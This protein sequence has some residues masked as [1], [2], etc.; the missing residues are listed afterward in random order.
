[1]SVLFVPAG[2]LLASAPVSAAAMPACSAERVQQLLSDPAT[3]GA[4][5][6]ALLAD[7]AQADDLDR[8]TAMLLGAAARDLGD[9]DR[10]SGFFEKAHRAAP[11]DTA[12]TLEWAV[13]RERARD[14]QTAGTLYQQVLAS[15]PASRPA[16]LGLAR[17][18]RAQYR[19]AQA[20]GIYRE[21]LRA[22]AHDIDA[23][24]GLA[25]VDLAEQRTG[26]ARHG[27]EA[28]LASDPDNA[29]AHEGLRNVATTLPY[30]LDV[31]A[32][33][34][35]TRE[36]NAGSAAIL[37]R[38]DLDATHSIEAGLSHYTDE[39][40]SVQLTTQAPLPTNALR[41][42]YYTHVPDGYNWA[43][44]YD[45]REHDALSDE[46]RVEARVGSYFAGNLQWFASVR[47]SF[48]GSEWDN[49]LVQ[50]GLVLPL[51]GRWEIAPT[52][53][54]EHDGSRR[55]VDFVGGRRNVYAYGV[56]V[57]RQGPGNSFL[58]FGAGSS[59]EISNV[60]VHARLV[61]PTSSRGALL[62]S[63]EHVS[64][65]HELLANVGWRFYWQ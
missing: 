55:G 15:D 38:A 31:T 41:L 37:L 45:Y 24:N 47:Q 33:G 16:R 63:I 49:R 57:N 60:D 32:G 27:F 35:R 26:D 5:R 51:G 8:T 23:A 54:Y 20:R 44:V 17:V 40:P 2:F 28:V 4:S 62:F 42:G 9:L 13:T 7:C 21:L 65:N 61:L 10:A 12:A 6:S 25:W 3:S 34:V 52:V 22:D 14:P 43:L 53:Y 56:D 1:M 58:N 30:Q 64:V 19:L 11:N 59:P 18:A 29:E 48:G 50:A 46:H 36:G 39:L